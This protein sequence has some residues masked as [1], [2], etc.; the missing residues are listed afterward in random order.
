MATEPLGRIAE[1]IMGQSPAGDTCNGVGEGLPLLNGPTEFGLH[2]PA[3]VQYTSD[4]RK[5]ARPGDIL[6][7]VRG[8]TTGRM[9][10]ADREYAI[11]RGIAAIR[12]KR[13]PDYQ[14]FLRGL[15][16]FRL[17]VL[18]AQATGSTFPNVSY[19]QLA[20][21]VCDIADEQQ[22]RA[23][24]SLL[25]AFDDKI[26]L[27]RQMNETLETLARS[28]FQFW[29]LD[30]VQAGLPQGWREGTLG[31]ITGFLAG[32]AF[33][34]KDWIDQGIP[35]VKIGSIKP[36][37]VD[38]EEVSFVSD[39]VAKEAQRFRLS[40][41]D[42]LI[43]MTGYVGEVGLV[44]PTDNLPLLNQRVGKFVPETPG[45]AALGFL[46]CLTRR[47]EFKAQIGAKAHGTAQANVSADAILSVPIVIPEK[48]LQD[49]FNRVCE[50]ILNRI[51]ANHD[52]SRTLG[53]VRDA[54]LPRLF[55]VGL[56]ALTPKSET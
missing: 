13:G 6:F 24:A 34:S 35:V 2:H 31:E 22:Q 37:I 30:R 52:E 25:E 19:D 56:R 42:L 55:S 12:H 45:T 4:P 51:L 36:G 27:N 28:I 7:C 49:E 32:Y 8:S 38:L 1:I 16:N 26:E 17:P 43:G 20:G 54:L 21:L 53:T 14:H 18:L 50:P 15:I 40:P 44:P 48:S 29:F 10:W 23:I 33:K 9:N 3:P 11:G 39:E 41:G 5:I 47:Q 46:Y